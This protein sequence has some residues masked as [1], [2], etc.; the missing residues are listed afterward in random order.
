LHL[1]DRLRKLLLGIQVDGLYQ[2]PI[3]I[4]GGLLGLLLVGGFEVVRIP[5]QLVG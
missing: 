3:E 2:Y 5:D 4:T 1:L